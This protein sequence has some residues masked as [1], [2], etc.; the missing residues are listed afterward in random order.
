MMYKNVIRRISRDKADGTRVF[1]GY[2][3]LLEASGSHLRA[4]TLVE[5]RREALNAWT[6]FAQRRGINVQKLCPFEQHQK[7][8]IKK[9]QAY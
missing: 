6:T 2:G 7:H 5:Q 8:L 3:S 9:R 1:F 4:E